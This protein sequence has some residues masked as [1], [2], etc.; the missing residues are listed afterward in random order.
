MKLLQEKPT[1][2]LV[3]VYRLSQ[4]MSNEEPHSSI[5]S[6]R[7]DSTYSH[8]VKTVDALV[9]ENL[10][11]KTASAESKRRKRIELTEKGEEVSEKI[12]DLQNTISQQ[13]TA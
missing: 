6:K 4:P 7:I 11:E 5:I 1:A 8:T 2:I 9:E 10:L 3:E 12:L 13:A